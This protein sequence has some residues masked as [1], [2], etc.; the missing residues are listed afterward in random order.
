[1]I[2]FLKKRKE[3]SYSIFL[4]DTKRIINIDDELFC[5]I[6]NINESLVQYFIGLDISIIF[7]NIN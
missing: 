4:D 7:E 5:D 6:F 3:N 2:I 1:M